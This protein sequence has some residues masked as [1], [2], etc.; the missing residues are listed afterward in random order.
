MF[1]RAEA[2]EYAL[3]NNLTYIDSSQEGKLMNINKRSYK[4]QLVILVFLTVFALTSASWAATYYV[5]KNHPEASDS[6]SGSENLPWRTIQHAV[7]SVRAGDKVYIKEGIYSE[8]VSLTG[9]SGKEGKSGNA[10]D[11]YITY[12]GYPGETVI[13]DG[14]SF[15]WGG[16]FNSGRYTGTETL[17]SVNYIRIKDL[18]IRNYPANGIAFINDKDQT[19]QGSHH[20]L[21]ENLTIHNNGGAGIWIEGGV[22][23]ATTHDIILRNNT[24]YNN[25]NH[26]IKFDGDVA[27]FIDR[28]HIHDSIIENNIVYGSG[29]VNEGIGIHVSTGHY[30]ITVRNNTVYNNK[31]Q[32][33][34]AH[35]VWDSIYEKN[36]VYSNGIGLDSEGGGIA[37]WRSKNITISGNKVH[38]NVAG[39]GRGIELWNNLDGSP[40]AHTVVNNIIF[41]NSSYG[42]DVAAGSISGVKVYHNTIVSNQTGI[43]L[44]ATNSSGH[45]VRNNIIYQ[46]T[47]Q[48]SQGNGNTFDYN[49]YYPDVFFNEKGANS[50]Y[51]DP[52]FVDAE[53]N[54]FHLDLDSP[55]VDS[56]ANVG[57][58]IDI[59]NNPR[60]LGNG[61]DIGAYEKMY[62]ALSPPSG[63]KI[64]S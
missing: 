27:G 21:V 26:G 53:G 46:N 5:D 6:N 12:A 64:I 59:E 22:G 43:R 17:R 20:I 38:D 34:V 1:Q 63:L 52:M 37:I 41:N 32:G 25:G 33:L 31:H 44:S 28:E 11:G 55:A 62:Q 60:P 36:D 13:M 45:T 49:L 9:S 4:L 58:T 30:N 61:F 42:I 23:S 10:I 7:D 50:I 2:R 51:E 19:G 54:D 47:T 56:S 8:R 40:T 3:Q 39:T 14:N 16:A 18:V 57:I 15:S 35:E 24:V 29:Q 48:I